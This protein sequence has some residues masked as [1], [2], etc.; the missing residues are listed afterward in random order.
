MTEQQARNGW[1]SGFPTFSTP[2]APVI[3]L[4]EFI[5]DAGERQLR[6]WDESV[7][8]RQGEVKGALSVSEGAADRSAMLEYE[9]PIQTPGCG[10]SRQ[11]CRDNYRTQGKASPA[12]PDLDQASAYARGLRCQHRACEL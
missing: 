7:P 6:A 5:R 12:Q 10:A 1:G 4:E 8:P 11:E 3:R 2:S 9:L